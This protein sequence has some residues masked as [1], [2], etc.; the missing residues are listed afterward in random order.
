M[1]V[2]KEKEL[3]QEFYYA[4]TEATKLYLFGNYAQAVSLYK[5]CLKIKPLS[6][7][8]NFQLS[9]IYASA[10][11]TKIAE[12]H[13]RNAV[14]YDPENKWYLQNLG[15]IFQLE[16]KFDSA[17]AIY[18]RLLSLDKENVNIMYNLAL[19][20]ER[21]GNY[22]GAIHYL[23]MIDEKI[24]TSK[25]VSLS[26]YRLY[27]RMNFSDKAIEELLMAKSIDN[28][29]YN[30]LGMIAEYYRNHR[31]NDSANYYYHKIYPKFSNDPLVI[32][33]YAEYLLNVGKTDS[34]KILLIGAMNDTLYD[35]REKESFIYNIL[36]DEHEWKMY[37][38]MLD[39]LVTI[40]LIKNKNGLQAISLF[41]DV[42]LRLRNYDKATK[43][44]KHIVN[45]DNTNYTALEQLVYVLNI[46]GLPDSVIYY[47]SIALK[48]FTDKPLIYLFRGSAYYQE[49]KYQAAIE[50]IDKGIA[51][52]EDRE[53][54]IE[55]FALKAECFQGLNNYEKSEEAFNEA[56][57]MD[58]A[59]TT[60]KNNFAYYLSLR[61]KNLSKAEAM[62]FSTIRK[63]PENGTFL[64][65]YAWILFKQEKFKKAKKYIISAIRFG[66]SNNKDVLFH[67]T[68]IFI[69]NKD[70]QAAIDS[71][72]LV[73]KIAPE[74]SNDILKRIDEIRGLMK[75]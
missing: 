6:G 17:T 35:S 34:A 2:T 64:D 53:T 27:E 4:F 19:I 51:I 20:E 3:N 58:S 42:Q 52:T 75:K 48:N 70:Y 5:E 10:G 30:I 23:E 38:Y 33:S 9:K 21:S 43:A 60:I 8:T 50:D 55:L 24:G 31:K 65:T 66:G 47:A 69:K 54:K 61:D 26:K 12:I 28:S 63:E 39:T 72:L 59:N 32:F 37:R 44:L 49:K 36:Q 1:K 40:Q 74:E 46:R 11:N 14:K 41:A 18:R 67:A 56:L 7:A 57:K 68:E 45:Q 22:K 15:D 13:G 71:L 25:E 62:S 29:D 16:E 73:T